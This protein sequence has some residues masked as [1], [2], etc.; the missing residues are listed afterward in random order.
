MPAHS[1]GII[2]HNLFIGHSSYVSAGIR[3]AKMRTQHIHILLI[4]ILLIAVI[5]IAFASQATRSQYMQHPSG[6]FITTLGSVSHTASAASNASTSSNS[7]SA[8]ARAVVSS[9]SYDS[10]KVFPAKPGMSCTRPILTISCNDPRCNVGNC[11]AHGNSR[12]YKRH[13][14]IK[15]VLY[16]YNGG[17]TRS[18]LN[19]TTTH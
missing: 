16:S 18:K 12:V 17:A 8:F 19:V 5:P 2:F 13:G 7:R 15:S 3:G 4:G 14:P 10:C 11:V 6:G 9:C 1:R